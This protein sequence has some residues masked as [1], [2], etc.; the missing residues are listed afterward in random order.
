[1]AFDPLTA[2]FDIGGK[3][4]DRLIPDPTAKA[5][6][7]LALLK[8]QQDGEFHEM[9][10]R[11]ATMLAEA[12]SADPWTSRARPSFMYV[13]YIFMLAALPMGVLSAFSADTAAR[14]ADG[15]KAFLGAIPDGM[16]GTFGVGYVG[17]AAAR[18]YDKAKGT[19]K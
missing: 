1:M 13:M 12:Q 5:A 8:M 7:N 16:W 18:S 4:I 19:S 10:Q 2:A 6:A 9:D 17:Y 14:I 15:V 11:Y 3:L